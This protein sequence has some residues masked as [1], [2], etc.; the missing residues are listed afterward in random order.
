[1]SK[2][3]TLVTTITTMTSF[4]AIFTLI[5]SSVYY[6]SAPKIELNKQQVTRS[7]LRDLM[8]G[9][10]SDND[11]IKNAY[12]S[13]PIQ[14]LGMKNPQMIY[15]VFLKKKPH[16]VI[17]SICAPDGYGGPIYAM[18]AVDYEGKVLGIRVLSHKETPG[19]GDYIDGQHGAFSYQWLR[20]FWKKQFSLDS[21]KE[22][23]VKKD[24]GVFTYMTGATISPRALIKAVSKALEYYVK[25]RNKFYP[26][27]KK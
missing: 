18:L 9:I 16:A 13:P 21:N 6:W 2:I 14:E 7:L 5:M 24:G 17:F 12:Q 19:L 26:K 20:Q 3:R 1:M 15:P 10:T 25:H 11:P 22:W 23:A 27:E 8:Q 4:G